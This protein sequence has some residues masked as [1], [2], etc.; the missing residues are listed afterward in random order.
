M[1]TQT[2]NIQ[3]GTG[4]IGSVGLNAMR[5]KLIIQQLANEVE[6]GNRYE[7]SDLLD[8]PIVIFN[9]NEISSIDSLIEALEFVKRKMIDQ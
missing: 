2:T 4:K 1:I 7:S 6:I 9:F 8:S 3:F 5:G